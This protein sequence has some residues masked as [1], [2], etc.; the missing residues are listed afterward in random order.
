MKIRIII[1]ICIPMLA[2]IFTTASAQVSTKDSTNKDAAQ[3]PRCYWAGFGLGASTLGALAG[4]VNVNAE[5]SNQWIITANAEIEANRFLNFSSS[6]NV[7][8]T[9]YN[10]LAGKIYKGKISFFTLSAG[11]GLVDVY[12]YN[13]PGLFS[14]APVHKSDQYTVGVPLLIQWYVIRFQAVG[15]GLSGYANLNTIQT[16]AG[17]NISVVFGR[18][19]THKNGVKSL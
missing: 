16:T 7:Q 17:F 5:I 18:I 13:N 1:Y 11:I 3:I 4:N 9:T 6:P 19:A 15:I 2:F 12:T 10:V 14:D 8:V